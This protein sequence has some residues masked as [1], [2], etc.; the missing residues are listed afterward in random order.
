MTLEYMTMMESGIATLEFKITLAVR[1]WADFFS[2]ANSQVSY[3]L[4]G[5]PENRR[6]DLQALLW[7]DGK[8]TCEPEVWQNLLRASREI[9]MLQAAVDAALRSLTEVLPKLPFELYDQMVHI[10]TIL[11]LN[12]KLA[13][14]PIQ[15]NAGVWP[16]T[17]PQRSAVQE[18]A[19]VAAI[20]ARDEAEPKWMATK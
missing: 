17:R 12:K 6:R 9:K 13:G 14:K 19:L 7:T 5:P 4:V 15:E 3:I 1:K 10:T 2:S 8:R 16:V 18:A 20:K 11:E